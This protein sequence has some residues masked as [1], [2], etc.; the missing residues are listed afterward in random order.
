MLPI[1]EYNPAFSAANILA[2]FPIK[3]SMIFK[4]IKT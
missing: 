1:H 3:T 4:M 2:E